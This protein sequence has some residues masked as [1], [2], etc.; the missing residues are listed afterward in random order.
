LYYKETGIG[1]GISTEWNMWKMVFVEGE[2]LESS[3]RK[4]ALASMK[5]NKKLR[6]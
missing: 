3:E 5:T 6:P 4:T 1:N 2:N